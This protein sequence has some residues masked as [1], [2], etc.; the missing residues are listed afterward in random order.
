LLQRLLRLLRLL[1]LVLL[2]RLGLGILRGGWGGRRLRGRGGGSNA[3]CW[4]FVLFR[5]LSGGNVRQSFVKNKGA[6]T[7]MPFD[8]LFVL[9]HVHVPSLVAGEGM[10]IGVVKDSVI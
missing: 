7:L 2:F 3:L 4:A 10:V 5:S 6:V 8:C 1:W 9:V